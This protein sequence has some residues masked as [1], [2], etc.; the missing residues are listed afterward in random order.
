MRGDSGSTM[1][2]LK[3]MIDGNI[4]SVNSIDIQRF[5]AMQSQHPGAIC[6]KAILQ[7]CESNSADPVA[8]GARTTLLRVLLEQGALENWRENDG[9]SKAV[10]D[11]AAS[12][13]LPTGLQGVNPSEFVAATGSDARRCRSSHRIIRDTHLAHY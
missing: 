9:L 6:T 2:D 13:P 7:V 12:F 10:F 8:V 1:L 3:S 4:P 5:W 11:A